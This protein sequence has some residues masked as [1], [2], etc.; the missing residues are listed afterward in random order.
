M[1]KKIR[2]VQIR[3][4]RCP[5]CKRGPVRNTTWRTILPCRPDQLTDKD[6]DLF[7]FCLK[8]RWYSR[9]EY[10]CPICKTG[11]LE[12]TRRAFARPREMNGTDDDPFLICLKCGY[13]VPME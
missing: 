4:R 2:G 7:W 12:I 1:K 8:C 6:T 3:V 5:L 11:K 9:V 10:K 13:S